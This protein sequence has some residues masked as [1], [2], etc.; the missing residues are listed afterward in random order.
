MAKN[1]EQEES[2]A[3][4]AGTV[5]IRNVGVRKRGGPELEQ[6][7]KLTATLQLYTKLMSL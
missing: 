1:S 3:G 7:T 4:E 5:I 6:A 2:K